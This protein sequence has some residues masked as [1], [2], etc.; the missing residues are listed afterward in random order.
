M[1]I[2]NLLLI[3]F[4]VTSLWGNE[5]LAQNDSSPYI[6]NTIIDDTLSLTERD[7]YKLFP[8]FDEFR[9]AVFYL[10]SDST[11]NAQVYYQKR[12]VVVDTLIQNYRTLKNLNYHIYARDALE[13]GLPLEAFNYQT[14]GYQKGDEVSAYMNDG[15]EISG[16]LL[17]VRVNS[18]LLLNSDCNERLLKPECINQIKASEIDK[19]IIEGNSNLGWGIGL[20][21][22]ASVVV[23]A[24][25]Y[26]SNYQNTSGWF[27]EM[28]AIEKS[29]SPIVLSSIGCITLGVTIGI[30]TSTKDEVIKIYSEDDI[31][32]LSYYSR[33]PNKEP[34]ELRKVK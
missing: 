22:L 30:F 13:K 25:I 19:L 6:V 24:F 3:G 10:N 18:I 7:Y 16:E 29:I 33:Y 17:S 8:E 5:I 31:R 21:I 11:L 26:S 4:T 20:G 1:K 14:S 32:G 34:D 15:R 2:L 23:G 27:R 12:G 9:L 28:N